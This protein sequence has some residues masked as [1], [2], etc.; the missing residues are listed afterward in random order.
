MYERVGGT[1][2]NESFRKRSKIL[3]VDD[4]PYN[5][6]I[7]Q[8]ILEG[9]YDILTAGHAEEAL[10][11]VSEKNPPDLVLLDI[12][13]PDMDGYEVCRRIKADPKTSHIPII[14]VT[15]R[16]ATEDEA[17]GLSM[18]AVDYITK[19]YDAAIIRARVKTHIELIEA[20]RALQKAHAELYHELEAMNELQKS[21]LPTE[22]FIS[23]RLWA[24]G[25]YI[26]SGLTGGDYFDYFPMAEGGLRCVVAD[27]SGHGAKAAFIMAMVRT[28][29]HFD[30]SGKYSLSLLVKILNDH[31][32]QTF[33]D[34]G[35]FVT[36]FAADI[37]P[38]KASMEY[39]SAG[40]CPAFFMNVDGFMEVDSTAA[41]LGVFDLDFESKFMEIH[42]PWKMLIYTDG[43][44]ECSVRGKGIF[45]YEN[46]LNL[47]RKLLD[48]D[49]LQ[50]SDLPLKVIEHASGIVGITDDQTA[51]YI[52]SRS[53]MNEY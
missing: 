47:C 22:A 39:V 8:K 20:G 46:F 5:V 24:E 27:V 34:A 9:R 29:F 15:A 1:G 3:I 25:I 16:T 51:L 45:G 28:L 14:F 52:K 50:V 26:P 12:L 41:L 4:V 44:Y 7:L 37:L 2:M 38:E 48:D 33:K 43:M 17:H 35:E 31:L 40:H 6:L 36:L 42:D 49:D 32:R 13:M 30:E 19:P 18:G 53:L 23:D 10:R 21:I 11:I